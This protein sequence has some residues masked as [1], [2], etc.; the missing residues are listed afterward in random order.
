MKKYVILGLIV[1]VGVF[2]YVRQTNKDYYDLIIVSG[3][4]PLAISKKVNGS[5]S[6]TITGLVKKEYVF[7]GN[8]LNGFAATRIRTREFSADGKYQGAYAYLGIPV[9]NILE[10]IAPQKPDDTNFNQPLDIM[11]TFISSSGKTATFSFNEIIMATDRHPITLAYDRQPLAPTSEEALKTY[12]YNIHQRNLN[13]LRLI[14]PKEP[15]ITR[16]LDDVVQISYSVL[17]TPD[18]TVTEAKK[19]SEMRQ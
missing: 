11:V 7:N 15:D 14:C 5:I 19:R 8:T 18:A 2:V 1:L 17:P 6:L 10:G 12:G 9:F 4:T 13:G 16:F 3:A